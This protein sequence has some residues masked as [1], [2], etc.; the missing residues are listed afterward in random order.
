MMM[1][2]TTQVP[3]Q[4][5]SNSILPL[6]PLSP[7][8]QTQ[9]CIYSIVLHNPLLP[10][11]LLP[12]QQQTPNSYPHVL[13]F[14]HHSPSSPKNHNNQMNINIHQQ[15]STAQSNNNELPKPPSAIPPSPLFLTPLSPTSSSIPS[16]RHYRS[17]WVCVRMWLDLRPTPVW[18]NNQYQVLTI[19]DNDWL[20]VQHSSPH[21]LAMIFCP[22]FIIFFRSFVLI[23]QLYWSTQ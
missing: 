8:P 9:K 4:P 11:D 16:V 3:P 7:L 15:Q 5:T 23:I 14:C 1:I 18:I 21:K 12:Q 20:R 19:N 13:F 17:F 6:S 10:E 22:S 2:K